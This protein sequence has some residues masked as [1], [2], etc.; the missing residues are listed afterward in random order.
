MLRQQSMRRLVLAVTMLVLV[1]PGRSPQVTAQNAASAQPS[2]APRTPWGDPDLQ[3]LWNYG[4]NTPLQRPPEFDGREMN[5]LTASRA[6]DDGG[7]G[8]QR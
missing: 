4:T 7:T 8:G 3:G 6:V 2:P 5:A 1:A